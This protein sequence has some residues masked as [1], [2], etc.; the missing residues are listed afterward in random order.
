MEH[1]ELKP[2]PFCG[3]KASVYRVPYTSTKYNPKFSVEGLG[4]L[5]YNTVKNTVKY[6][7][8]CNKCKALVG[9]YVTEKSAIA[10][11]NRRANNEM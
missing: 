2:C 4:S 7:I 3:H 8:R 5:G 9:A 10:A 1:N 6:A 11:W